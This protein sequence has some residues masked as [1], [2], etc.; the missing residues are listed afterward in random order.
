MVERVELLGPVQ[1]VD[2]GMTTGVICDQILSLDQY[3]VDDPPSLS[4][5]R[6]IDVRFQ[7]Q[8]CLKP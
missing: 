6:Y 8:S 5:T 4:Q 1:A 7:R 2:P 3:A